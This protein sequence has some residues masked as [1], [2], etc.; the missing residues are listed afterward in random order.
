MI[1]NIEDYRTTSHYQKLAEILSRETNKWQINSAFDFIS[2]A[3]KGVDARIIEN[4]LEYFDVS[5][6]ET[7]K[8]LN[9]SEPTIYRWTKSK[10]RLDR[11]FSVQVFELTDLFLYGEEVFE[12]QESFF[13]WMELPNTAL[14]G[15]EPREILGI[16][17][18]I[19]KVRDLLGRIDFGVYS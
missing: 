3:T 12:N 7:S 6:L 11:N 19:S 16:P 2:I 14:G 13:L 5:K 9:I 10:K 15:F 8:L 18:G 17:G 4:F 1:G